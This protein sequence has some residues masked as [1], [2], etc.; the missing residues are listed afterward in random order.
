MT[1]RAGGLAGLV[2][3]WRGKPV[4]GHVG[5]EL[6]PYLDQLERLLERFQYAPMTAAEALAR[7]IE[8]DRILHGERQP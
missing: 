2:N 4:H 6:A 8:L 7:W 3:G 1:K 5:D